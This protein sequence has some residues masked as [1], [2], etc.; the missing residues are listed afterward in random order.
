MISSV[1]NE[2]LSAEEINAYAIRG[3]PRSSGSGIKHLLDCNDELEKMTLF[4]RTFEV[5]KVSSQFGGIDH[6]SVPTVL[7][8]NTDS[9]FKPRFDFSILISTILA[10]YFH[11]N[12]HIFSKNKESRIMIIFFQIRVQSNPE[13]FVDNPCRFGIRKC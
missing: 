6:N 10:D 11:F 8:R 2:N 4:D 9:I 13:I 1:Y 12:V 5:E 7:T 3:F